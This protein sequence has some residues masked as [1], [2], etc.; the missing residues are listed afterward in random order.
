MV[1][2]FGDGLGSVNKSDLSFDYLFSKYGTYTVS[3]TA[4]NSSCS[5]K[6]ELK[7]PVFERPVASYTYNRNDECVGGDVNF[8]TS[9]FIQSSLFGVVCDFDEDNS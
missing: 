9:T 4:S 2:D 8:K 7:T 5:T 1:W 3:L 6:Y